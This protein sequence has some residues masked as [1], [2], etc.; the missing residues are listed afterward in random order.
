MIKGRFT[1]GVNVLI[2]RKVRVKSDTKNLN[3][4]GQRDWTASDINR[5]HGSVTYAIE[6][7][8]SRQTVARCFNETK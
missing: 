3:M 7:V 6:A 1:D 4:V 8:L 2:Q 5:V